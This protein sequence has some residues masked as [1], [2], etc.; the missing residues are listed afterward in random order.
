MAIRPTD[1]Q[2]SI[3]NSVQSS[4]TAQRSEEAPR[5]AAAATQAAFSAQQTKREESIAES[6][7]AEGNRVAANPE[8]RREEPDG[9]KQRRRPSTPFD[10][11][12]DEAAG[13]ADEAPHF[14]DF[15]A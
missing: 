3:L 6:G 15:S 4:A 2:S 12:V 13:L 8:R 9:R 10:D 7:Q 1:L 5:Q 14:I 11:V